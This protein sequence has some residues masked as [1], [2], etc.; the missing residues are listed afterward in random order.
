MVFMLTL[1]I[2][3]MSEQIEKNVAEVR[4]L[5]ARAAEKSGRNED[6]ITIVGVSKRQPIEKIYDAHRAGI[7]IFGENRVQELISKISI[8]EPNLNWHMIGHLQGNKANKVVG[9]VDMIQSVDSSNLIERLSALG[10]Q[11]NYS[12][13]ILLQVNTSGEASK[14]GFQSEQVEDICEEIENSEYIVLKG[15]MTI[16]P[17]TRDRGLISASFAKLRNL[18]ERLK[19]YNSSKISMTCLSMGMS[20]DFEIAILEGSN[21]VRIGTAIFG[22]REVT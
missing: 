6:D 13:E 18:Y 22:P 2:L 4:N 20:D 16:G 9:N 14:F 5:I 17:L 11:R 21:L 15:L 7:K 8:A 19:K 12:S 3:V 10:E 1:L